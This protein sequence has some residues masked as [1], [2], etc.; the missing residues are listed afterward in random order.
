MIQKLA[1]ALVLLAIVGCAS[2]F[3]SGPTDLTF[4]S[5]PEGAEVLINNE[6]LGTTPVLL[7]LHAEKKYVITYRKD[8]CEDATVQLN[9]HVQAGY[10]VLDFFAPFGL[11]VDLITGEWKE[12]NEDTPFV[13]MD[14]EQTLPA[15]EVPRA[16]EPARP[17]PA[18]PRPEQPEA[19]VPGDRA[20]RAAPMGYFVAGE[21][22]TTIRQPG[23]LPYSMTLLINSQQN[24]GKAVG[25][26]IY[27]A[28]NPCSYALVLEY[29]G[30]NDMVLAQELVSGPCE[31]GTRIVLRR[32]G[33]Q[34]SGEWLRSDNISWF[35]GVLDRSN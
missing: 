34:L 9:T 20:D 3:S 4:T 25:T 32:S 12:F 8:G 28:E 33:E 13:T 7:K 15:A 17:R 22:T 26:A 6:P 16:A 31:T 29:V 30:G 27:E 10:V 18:V 5:D 11:I 19:Q 14:C 35:S 23:V 21:W 2:I 1:A 24:I